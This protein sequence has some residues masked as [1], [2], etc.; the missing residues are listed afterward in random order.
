M[1]LGY[2]RVS[3]KKQNLNRQIDALEQAGCD[4]VYMEKETGTKRNRPELNRM[5]ENLNEGDTVIF[6]ELARA[7]RSTKDLLEIV[8]TINK[9]GASVK[10]L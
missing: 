6:A 8:D 1:L 7:S 3:T 4:V 2:A 10:S 5:L 9:K